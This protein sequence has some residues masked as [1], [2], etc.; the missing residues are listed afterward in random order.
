MEYLL[1]AKSN[2][3]H[4]VII[5]NSYSLYIHMCMHIYVVLVHSYSATVCMY[6]T[7][8][9]QQGVVTFIRPVEIHDR[10]IKKSRLNFI[11]QNSLSRLQ[12]I[13]QVL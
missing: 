13:P 11:D 5:K 12:M 6:N 9:A 10:A 3:I 7:Q 2:V 8:Q 4:Y 1:L